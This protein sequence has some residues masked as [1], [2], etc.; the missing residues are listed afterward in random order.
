FFFFFCFFFFFFFFQAEDGIRDFHVTGVQTCALPISEVWLL[1]RRE[2]AFS[3]A[4]NLNSD[5]ECLFFL[6]SSLFFWKYNSIFDKKIDIYIKFFKKNIFF[7][8]FYLFLVGFLLNYL[9][10]LSFLSWFFVYTSL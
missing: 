7:D 9:L 2:I 3:T 6:F 5:I 4:L 10:F 8:M 1:F